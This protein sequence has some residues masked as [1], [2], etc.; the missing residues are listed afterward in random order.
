MTFRSSVSLL[1]AGALAVALGLTSATLVAQPRSVPTPDW[2]QVEQE[3]LRHF[4][5]ILRM[6]T[7]NPPGNETQVVQYL[8]DVLT[9]EG[10]LTLGTN[11]YHQYER[12]CHALELAYV[13][14]DLRDREID[15]RCANT[16]VLHAGFDTRC[17][18]ALRVNGKRY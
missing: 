9:K 10:K 2:A 18:S 5:A 16:G 13:L 15:A 17:S 1:C 14:D 7:A 3:T 6:D 4:Q 11:A 12:L 8:A